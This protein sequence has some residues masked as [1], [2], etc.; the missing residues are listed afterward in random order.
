MRTTYINI[1]MMAAAT[2]QYH[3]ACIVMPL[4]NNLGS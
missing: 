1:T 2:S 4:E 3:I